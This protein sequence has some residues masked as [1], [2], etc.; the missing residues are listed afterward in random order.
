MGAVLAV[1]IASS[2]AEGCRFL[3]SFAP[4][5]AINRSPI[6]KAGASEGVGGAVDPYL[7]GRLAPLDAETMVCLLYDCSGVFR[8][9]YADSGDIGSV[10]VDRTALLRKAIEQVFKPEQ[11]KPSYYNPQNAF[12]NN[13]PRMK[14]ATWLRCLKSSSAL[15]S[16]SRS[17]FSR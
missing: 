7:V 1:Q 14:S 3:L 16:L 10:G 9:E 11:I 17:S 5:T 13:D 6:S 4:W 15:R 8:I 2:I 12:I